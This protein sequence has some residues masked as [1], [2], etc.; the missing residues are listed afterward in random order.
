MNLHITMSQSISFALLRVLS[1]SQ[2]AVRQTNA[3]MYCIASISASSASHVPIPAIMPMMYVVFSIS[4]WVYRS[5][6][7]VSYQLASC[8]LQSSVIAPYP[9]CD[10]SA[11]DG[12]IKLTSADSKESDRLA[13]AELRRRGYVGTDRGHDSFSIGDSTDS[14]PFSF[15]YSDTLIVLRVESVSI[16]Y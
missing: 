5:S 16:L 7:P 11:L 6:F 13:R 10:Q 8:E 9:A 4:G 15:L 3:S 14:P 1:P 12:C 2:K